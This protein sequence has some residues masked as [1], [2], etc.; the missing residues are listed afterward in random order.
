MG[1]STIVY[2]ITVVKTT[3]STLAHSY[4]INFETKDTGLAVMEIS[5]AS[6]LVFG[7]VIG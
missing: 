6:V 2:I 5:A 7:R 4:S 3:I 1:Y